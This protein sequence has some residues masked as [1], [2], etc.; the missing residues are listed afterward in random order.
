[1]LRIGV[2]QELLQG[3]RN[4]YAVVFDQQAD[5][6]RQG[7]MPAVGQQA[8]RDIQ[9][10]AGLAA[11]CLAQRQLRLRRPVVRQQRLGD[12]GCGAALA[13]DQR[14]GAS[15]IAQLATNAQQVAGSGCAAGQCLTPRNATEDRQRQAQRTAG[16]I[17]TDQAQAAALSHQ[18]QT[19][20]ERF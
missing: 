12:G 1:M 5:F 9:R 7:N 19:T 4:R 18:V 14:Q 15:G 3:E 16:G 11:Q 17:T 6:R 2:T 13:E 10:R 8:I 20:G